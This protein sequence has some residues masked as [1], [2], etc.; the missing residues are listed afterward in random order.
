VPASQLACWRPCHNT[1]LALG[2]QC[3]TNSVYCRLRHCSRSQQ[4]VCQRPAAIALLTCR[5]NTSDASPAPEYTLSPQTP[6]A[7][8]QISGSW[9]AAFAKPCWRALRRHADG[10]ALDALLHPALAD[11]LAAWKRTRVTQLER[12]L[13]LQTETMM[14]QSLH[15]PPENASELD[16]GTCADARGA[17]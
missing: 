14:P 13:A 6:A 15:D 2:G 1:S 16:D 5:T 8:Q 12:D 3:S 9:C 4:L 7:P 11:S 10:G 17:C